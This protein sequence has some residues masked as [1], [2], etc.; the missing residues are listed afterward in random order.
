M[1]IQ[2]ICVCFVHSY[3]GWLCLV[4]PLFVNFVCGQCACAILNTRFCCFCSVIRKVFDR[5]LLLVVFSVGFLSYLPVVLGSVLVF[6]CFARG[7]CL[8]A[9]YM[10]GKVTSCSSYGGLTVS[11]DPLSCCRRAL[12]CYRRVASPASVLAQ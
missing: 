11:G 4:F 3:Q 8:E 5:L 10:T 2:F 6:M 1:K 9:R 12:G 7:G